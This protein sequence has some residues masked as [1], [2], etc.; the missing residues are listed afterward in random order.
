M[1]DRF[2]V[3][4][5]N[6]NPFS[7]CTQC[8][9][10]QKF[11]ILDGEGGLHFLYYSL[12]TDELI[13]LKAG[14]TAHLIY[15]EGDRIDKGFAMTLRNEKSQLIAAFASGQG[16]QLLSDPNAIAFLGQ[17]KIS[18][19]NSSEAGRENTECGTKIYRSLIFKSDIDTISLNPGQSQ[20]LTSSYNW[21]YRVTHVNRFNWQNLKCN[22]RSTP[23][24]YFLFRNAAS[25]I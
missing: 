18:E 23:F 1:I 25:T 11:A 2:E 22:D 13:P 10:N 14:E 24:A 4:R 15:I 3:A 17:I 5:E 8:R 7:N 16:G 21:T 20:Q 9:F 6:D 19:N 12:P